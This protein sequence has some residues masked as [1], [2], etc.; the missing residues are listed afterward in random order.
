[1]EVAL[2]SIEDLATFLEGNKDKAL[3]F[4]LLRGGKAQVVEVPAAEPA[5]GEKEYYIGVAI[6][7]LDPA[8][9]AQLGLEEGQGIVVSEVVEDSPAAKAG[10]QAN[11]ILLSIDDKPIEGVEGIVAQ[12]QETGGAAATLKYLRKGETKSVEVTPVSRPATTAVRPSNDVLRFFGPGVMV[13]PEGGAGVP[14]L[15]G[16]PS[17]A[18]RRFEFRALPDDLRQE[19]ERMREQIDRLREQIE[20][21]KEQQK[22]RPDGEGGEEG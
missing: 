12:V 19:V 2:G 5:E 15:P 10:L 18:P 16:M 20:K 1:M 6:S 13:D 11:D 7:P 21:L 4:K 22:P 9:A 14:V 8:L 17:V 3:T